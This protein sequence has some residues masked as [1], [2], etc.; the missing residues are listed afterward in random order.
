MP[1]EA[2]AV[3]HDPADDMPFLTSDPLEA[4][5]WRKLGHQV[6]PVELVARSLT[7]AG[8]RR[9]ILRPAQP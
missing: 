3:W 9:V 4:V 7:A 8:R 1:L 2:W 5:A 6:E